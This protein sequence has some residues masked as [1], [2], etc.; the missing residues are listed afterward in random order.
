MQEEEII[1]IEAFTLGKKIS[2]HKLDTLTNQNSPSILKLTNKQ[3]SSNGGPQLSSRMY[4]SP[5]N[6]I[7]KNKTIRPSYSPPIK[8]VDF[9]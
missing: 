2:K 1:R 6:I 8:K 7:R 5:K 4:Q 3:K 9:T